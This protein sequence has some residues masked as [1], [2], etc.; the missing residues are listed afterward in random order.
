MRSLHL[1]VAICAGTV[2]QLIAPRASAQS[3]S[4]YVCASNTE[5]DMSFSTKSVQQLDPQYAGA[6]STSAWGNC[7]PSHYPNYT[8]L[9]RVIYGN[10][11]VSQIQFR[12]DSMSIEQDFDYLKVFKHDTFDYRFQVAA[13]SGAPSVPFW[14]TATTLNGSMQK[15]PAQ[16]R[17][18]S[19][20]S[21]TGSGAVVG[22]ARATCSANDNGVV[23]SLPEHERV[24]GILFATNDTV[25]MRFP[26]QT[27]HATLALWGD[28]VNPSGND[29]DLYV[30]C[31]SIPTALDWTYRS[32]RTGS[33]EFLHINEGACPSGSTWYV[34]VNS[35]SQKGFFN[36]MWA[37]HYASQHRNLD[38]GLAYR[39][40]DSGSV[41]ASNFNT[42]WRDA[43]RWA[44]GA[45]EGSIYLENMYNHTTKE[46]TM[47]DGRCGNPLVGCPWLVDLPNAG[48]QT[49]G[50]WNGASSPKCWAGDYKCIAFV[51]QSASVLVR[52][53]EWGHQAWKQPDEYTDGVGA[54]CGHTLMATD[55]NHNLCWSGNHATDSCGACTPMTGVS[56]WEILFNE[57]LA[58]W[59]PTSTPDAYDYLDFDFANLIGQ[60]SNPL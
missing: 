51:G 1:L 60:V 32:Y 31:G 36:L 45:S 13:Y 21:V 28:A 7:T 18:T 33:Q 38:V 56:G 58:N 8:D 37:Q 40:Q 23:V 6:C 20:Y 46:P 2:V 41:P 42:F 35:Y 15:Y 10:R 4:P 12:V 19:D 39:S 5:I 50:S 44:F 17:F 48:G 43:A 26:V 53:H 27:G 3:F 34:A 11:Y 54:R 22:K 47:D 29:Y 16:L 55:T 30:K 59:K 14:T 57:G 52:L 25:I 24:S 49:R 9:R